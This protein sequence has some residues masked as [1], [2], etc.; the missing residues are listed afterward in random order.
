GRDGAAHRR[1]AGP[2]AG[3]PHL[4]RG[5]ARAARGAGYPRR[6]PSPGG[7]PARSSGRARQREGQV[8]EGN[9]RRRTPTATSAFGVSRR[10]NHDTAA[11]YRRF[12]PPVLSD[13]DR[14]APPDVGDETFVCDARSMDAN[15]S[16]SVALAVPPPRA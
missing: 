8:A 6:A 5:I 10:E 9:G 2:G 7:S 12:S 3:R 11:F 13:D 14:V 16:P 15:P 4:R 1:R